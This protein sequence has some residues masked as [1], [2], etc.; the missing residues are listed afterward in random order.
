MKR[1]RGSVYTNKDERLVQKKKE[2]S[3]GVAHK[4]RS[5]KNGRHGKEEIIEKICR[6]F[7]ISSYS[8]ITKRGV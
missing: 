8:K 5:Q 2:R 4:Y 6:N 1:V 3:S 7:F